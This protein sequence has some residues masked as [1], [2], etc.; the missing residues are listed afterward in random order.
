MSFLGRER[1]ITGQV[2]DDRDPFES[3]VERRQNISMNYLQAVMDT[4]PEGWESIGTG[5]DSEDDYKV[6]GSFRPAKA[7]D[8][9]SCVTM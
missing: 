8:E 4:E 9:D 7:S 3:I 1:V 6:P 5:S 2:N